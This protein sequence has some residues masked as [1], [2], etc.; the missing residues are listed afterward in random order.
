MGIAFMLIAGLVKL[1]WAEEGKLGLL[2]GESSTYFDSY[3]LWEVAV[4]DLDRPFSGDELVIR[5]EVLSDLT[6]D[7]SRTFTHPDLPFELELSGFVKNASVMPKGPNWQASGPVVDG[8]GILAQ[9]PQVENEFNVAALH[10]K[11]KTDAGEQLGILW[12]NQFAPWTVQVGSQRFAVDMRHERYPMPFAIRLDDFIKDD[13]PGMSMARAFKSYVTKIDGD[14]EE[15]VL[16]QMNEP[17]RQDNLILFQSSFN[18]FNG[19]EYSVFSVVRNVSDKWP[20]Y[21]LWVT[22]FGMLW[23]FGVKLVLFV[24]RQSK[25]TA[26]LAGK[27]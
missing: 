6:G 25:R 8:Y 19:R 26:A 15:V 7:N 5:D 14:G 12:G 20:E 9:P 11:A 17:L 22:T 10:A 13:H 1:Y 3:Y 24:K 16:I 2:E 4:W 21:S 27:Q 18:Q 23:V